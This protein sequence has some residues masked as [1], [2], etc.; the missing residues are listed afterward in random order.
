[1]RDAGGEGGGFCN[2]EWRGCVLVEYGRL[3]VGLMAG[4][5]HGTPITAAFQNGVDVQS[6][7]VSILSLS[8]FCFYFFTWLGSCLRAHRF[9]RG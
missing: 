7:A 9:L 5:S 2:C 3:I 6:L 4:D 1:M 8:F